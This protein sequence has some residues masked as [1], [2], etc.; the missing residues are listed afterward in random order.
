MHNSNHTG[1]ELCHPASQIFYSLVYEYPCSIGID[2]IEKKPLY[3]FFPGEKTLSIATIG[4]NFQCSFCQN[5]QI[6]KA[7]S[8][9]INLKF[10]KLKPKEVIKLCKENNCKIISYTYTEPTIFYE[11][12][13]DIAKLA[14]QEG[15]KNIIVSNGFINEK[16]LKNLCKYIDAA[17]IDLK[18]FNEEFYKKNCKARL[19]PVMETLKL[20][21]QKK[22]WLEITNLIIPNENDDLEEI[23]KMV[24]WIAKELGKD[25]PLHFSKFHPDYKMKDKKSTNIEILN[26]AETIAKEKLNYVYVGNII[27]NNITICPKCKKEIIKRTPMGLEEN[28]LKQGRCCYCNEKIPGIWE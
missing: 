20:L 26:Q 11:Y 22:V 3:H 15:I 25:V 23:K 4:C 5:W 10:E 8:N 9:N 12:M 19:K 6:S 7:D 17:N 1:N 18:A 16:P 14:K 21:K 2:P 13:I 27:R 24:D 28:K